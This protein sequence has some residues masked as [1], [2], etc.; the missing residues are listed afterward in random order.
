M[1]I[2]SHEANGYD[3]TGGQLLLVEHSNKVIDTPSDFVESYA[4]WGVVTSYRPMR[5]L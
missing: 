1:G 4:N 2:H 5:S 3:V